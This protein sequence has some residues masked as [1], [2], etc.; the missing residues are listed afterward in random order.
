MWPCVFCTNNEHCNGNSIQCC[1]PCFLMLIMWG[2]EG[3]P[4]R[5]PHPLALVAIIWRYRH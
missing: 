1:C 5:S 2:L 3:C 4:G